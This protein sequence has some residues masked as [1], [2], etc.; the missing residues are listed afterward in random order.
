MLQVA[1]GSALLTIV[2]GSIYVFT[3]RYLAKQREEALKK[4]AILARQRRKTQ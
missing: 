1:L 3:M 4:S 2:S